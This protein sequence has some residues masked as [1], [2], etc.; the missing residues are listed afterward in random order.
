[1]VG[2]RQVLFQQFQ[3]LQSL[4]VRELR[5]QHG[6]VSFQ[7]VS[8]RIQTTERTQ[9]FRHI[10]HQVGINDGHIWGQRV[11]C[12]RIFLTS[13]VIGHYGERRHFRTGTG[14]GG[15]GDHLGFDAHFRE[16]VDT[17]TDIHKAQGQFFEVGFRMFVHDPHDFRRIHR[18]TAAQRD[19][20]VWF[21]G[22]RQIGTF[23]YDGQGRVSFN[24]EEDFGFTPAAF[25]TEVI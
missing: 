20:D 14:G 8:H 2:S 6:N 22:V 23:T 9:R 5:S 25:S 21:E 17:F 11:V 18:G 19:D 13:C 16:L 7:G 1:M 3:R 10:H 24:F 4:A 15:D 12:Q